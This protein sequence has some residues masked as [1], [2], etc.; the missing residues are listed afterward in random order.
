VACLSGTQW[1]GAVFGFLMGGLVGFRGVNAGGKAWLE[2][3]KGSE[4]A[5]IARYKSVGKSAGTNRSEVAPRRGATNAPEKPTKTGP[6]K[7]LVV[8][9]LPESV[10]RVY[11][12]SFLAWLLIVCQ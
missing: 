6:I 2:G 7:N 10:K 3:H 12:D 1:Q 4:R 5:G 11:R 8:Y 9:T